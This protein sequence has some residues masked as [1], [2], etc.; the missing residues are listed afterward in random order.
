MT[1]VNR[2]AYRQPHAGGQDGTAVQAHPH[3][4]R[5]RHDSGVPRRRADKKHWGAPARVRA[6]LHLNGWYETL[7]MA[8]W[9][10]LR[11]NDDPDFD[12]GRDMFDQWVKRGL[13]ARF[14]S[15]MHEQVPDALLQ[16][17][18]ADGPED[19]GGAPGHA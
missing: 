16:L 7:G 10:A 8:G 18:D 3:P 15:V 1:G 4:G 13:H 6:P 14:G 17:L 2:A 9:A 12:E 5:Y 19:G 11:M